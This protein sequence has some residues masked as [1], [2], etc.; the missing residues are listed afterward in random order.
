MRACRLAVC[1]SWSHT[2]AHDAT[3]CVPKC[4]ACSPE[5]REILE[6]CFLLHATESPGNIW[7]SIALRSAVA[8]VVAVPVALVVAPAVAGAVAAAAAVAETAALASLCFRIQR[9]YI[10]I[11]CK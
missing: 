9:S 6:V 1:G 3:P 7:N 2:D 11:G 8:A 5:A 10:S 4:T